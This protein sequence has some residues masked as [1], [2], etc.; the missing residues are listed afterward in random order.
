[1]LV[2]NW[3]G[4]KHKRTQWQESEPEYD[5][6]RNVTL[7]YCVRQIQTLLY[8]SYKIL[9][10]NASQAAHLKVLHE[11]KYRQ[12]SQGMN[13][14]TINVLRKKNLTLPQKLLSFSGGCRA[15]SSHQ[16]YL[17]AEKSG[18][19]IYY[20]IRQLFSC[21]LIVNI[22]REGQNA[23]WKQQL[24]LTG[25]S[26]FSSL[27]STHQAVHKVW[28]LKTQMKVR[29]ETLTMHSDAGNCVII[30]TQLGLHLR[31]LVTI[32]HGHN[33]LPPA[34]TC[35]W[36]AHTGPDDRPCFLR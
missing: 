33:K 3:R 10:I 13:N 20:G 30:C 8:Y 34:M 11:E 17:R 32:C 22:T 35:P 4:A 31:E 15:I 7:S 6:K 27:K 29:E 19:T 26:F 9:C 23:Q 1:M 2:F 24:T 25:I 18:W 14:Q 5:I 28:M 12:I 21:M 36:D 16:S